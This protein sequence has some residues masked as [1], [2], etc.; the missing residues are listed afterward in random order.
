M[1]SAYVT[2]VFMTAVSFAIAAP[3]YGD[4][5]PQPRSREL[6]KLR[7]KIEALEKRIAAIEHWRAEQ[8][9]RQA[10][11]RE[12]GVNPGPIASAC[13]PVTASTPLEQGMTLQ[14][15]WGGQWWAARVLEVLDGGKVT[16]HYLGWDSRW[17][18]T[19]PRSRL[20]LDAPAESSVV[21]PRIREAL[22]RGT[23]VV[24]GDAPFE[25]KAAWATLI[26]HML[27][28]MLESAME[29][30]MKKL[31]DELGITDEIESKLIFSEAVLGG[32][33]AQAEVISVYLVTLAGNAGQPHVRE[34]DFGN[35]L[36]I[37]FMR[38]S[39][40]VAEPVAIVAATRLVDG[41]PT[42]VDTFMTWDASEGRWLT[43]SPTTQRKA[44][45]LPE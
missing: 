2:W 6:S 37:R 5:G 44:L 14:V 9:R 24:E 25:E 29:E 32:T 33:D 36:T 8:R 17:D 10:E 4:D 12:V 40:P 7:G 3:A 30:G 41:Q 34:I 21:L 11:V 43:Y 18:E 22:E 39:G 1:K 26:D 45:K 16:I 20:Q 42:T 28:E 23:I 15:E 35:E 31:V 38:A 19:V 27:G 13:I